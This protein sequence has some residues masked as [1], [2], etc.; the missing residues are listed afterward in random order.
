[1]SATIICFDV[2]TSGFSPQTDEMVQLAAMA[3]DG[4]TLEIIEDS[5]FNTLIKP[6]NILSGTEEEIRL[7]WA[8]S[9]KAW[10]VNKKTRAE[11]EK[12]PLPEHVWKQFNNYVKKYSKG[13]FTGKP[14]AAGHNI[15]GFD[16]AWLDEWSKRFDK[17]DKQQL[18]NG[19]TVLDTLN[20]CYLWF[21]NLPNAPV[22]Y[23]FD[24][25]RPWLGVSNE[26]FHDALADVKIT[27]DLLIRFLK[28]HR[29]YGPKVK[30]AGSF[31]KKD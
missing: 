31:A 6:V 29:H 11:L 10:E 19:R 17:K 26:G 12:A 5:E 21:N 9:N 25:L 18:F 7:K 30:F 27:S 4:D 23:S 3:I 16:L 13:G 28:L 14:I 24:N 8:K 15:Q 2:E 20:L 22:S 1:M